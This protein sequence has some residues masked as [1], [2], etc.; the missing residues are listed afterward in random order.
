MWLIDPSVGLVVEVL[1][2]DDEGDF[3]AD[4]GQE[5]QAA[6]D[7]SLGFIAARGLSVEQFAELGLRSAA[8]FAIYR[9][10]KSRSIE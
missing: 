6:Q 3:V 1:G 7:G 9:G 8:R 10:H 4:F 2:P 5:Q